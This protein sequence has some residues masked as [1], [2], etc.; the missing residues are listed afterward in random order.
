MFYIIDPHYPP[1][2]PGWG[3]LVAGRQPKESFWKRTAKTVAAGLLGELGRSS[4]KHV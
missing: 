4:H 1:S 3:V 2:P